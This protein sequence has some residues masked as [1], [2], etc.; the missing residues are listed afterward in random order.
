MT[1]SLAR[2]ACSYASSPRVGAFLETLS[3]YRT[4]PA[5][6]AEYAAR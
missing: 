1:P 5:I 6:V 2:T 4:D 3:R